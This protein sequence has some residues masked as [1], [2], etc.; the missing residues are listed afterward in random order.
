MVGSANFTRSGLTS[1][2]EACIFL[3]SKDQAD[4]A[5]LTAIRRWINNFRRHNLPEIDFELARAVYQVR[6][7]QH[8]KSSPIIL[9]TGCWALK[10]G[11]SGE[12]WQ[13]WL[14]ENVVSIGWRKLPDTS[15]MSRS[16]AVSAYRAARPEDP[17]GKVRTNVPQILNFT[18]NMQS[19]QLVLV[20]GRYDGVGKIDRDVYIYG[21]AR[22]IEVNGQC[23]Y[24]DTGST[25]H[26]CKRHAQIQRIEQSLPRSLVG[27]AV[28]R[29]SFVPTIMP[30]DQQR[31]NAL[32]KILRVELGVELVV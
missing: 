21:V 31:F 26:R 6:N 2:Q 32:E 15:R 23:Y 16:E 14:A 4:A 20:C 11:R 13:N 8:P 12:F 1:N 9:G 18:Q 5:Q 17:D 25:W 27:Q 19:G 22:T 28:Q 30:L 29:N 3:D 10:P 24:F 7:Q